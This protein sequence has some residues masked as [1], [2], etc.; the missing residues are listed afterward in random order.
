[1]PTLS[2]ELIWVKMGQQIQNI[3]LKLQTKDTH[4]IRVCICTSS[5]A[6]LLLGLWIKPRAP[7]PRPPKSWKRPSSPC[8]VTD[9][10]TWWADTK[11]H[12]V[13]TQTYFS[14]TGNKTL[15]IAL[16][17]AARQQTILV[18]CSQNRKAEPKRE[19]LQEIRGI[20]EEFPAWGVCWSDDE[21]GERGED[22]HFVGHVKDQWGDWDEDQAHP[23]DPRSEHHVCLSH[24]HIYM[25]LVFTHCRQ[26]R[27]QQLIR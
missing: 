11:S 19:F 8:K 16:E 18:E 21:R 22:S 6:P 24:T 2:N 3:N 13:L 10:S 7:A 4:L 25:H 1:M 17:S 26:C 9:A 15:Q 27:V 20:L 5:H 14:T 12:P 23:E